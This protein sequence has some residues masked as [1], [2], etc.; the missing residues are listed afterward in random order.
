MKPQNLIQLISADP[1]RAEAERF[2]I[3]GCPYQQYLDQKD[4]TLRTVSEAEFNFIDELIDWD[5]VQHIAQ[6]GESH[7]TPINFS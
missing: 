2:I 1:A 6:Q 5:M 3:R 4:P 7:P